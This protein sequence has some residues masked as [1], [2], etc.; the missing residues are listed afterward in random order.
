M[1]ETKGWNDFFNKK[2]NSLIKE[3]INVIPNQ[4]TIEWDDENGY[5][6]NINTPRGIFKTNVKLIDED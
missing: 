3:S 1:N 2:E 5:Y 6:L 4:M